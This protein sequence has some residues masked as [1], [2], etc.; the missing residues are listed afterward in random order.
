MKSLAA[1]WDPRGGFRLLCAH[2]KIRR[3]LEAVRDRMWRHPS[4]TVA[5]SQ[6]GRL[7]WCAK[8]PHVNRYVVMYD[9]RLN[10]VPSYANGVFTFPCTLLEL[11][12]WR[13]YRRSQR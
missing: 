1:D 3:N 12:R 7:C 5:R 13:R 10:R 2:G 11:S 9:N 4:A 8:K 6:F